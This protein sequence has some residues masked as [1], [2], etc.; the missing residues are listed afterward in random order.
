MEP[1][2][3]LQKPLRMAQEGLL[4]LA[5]LSSKNSKLNFYSYSNNL[6][7]LFFNTLYK[8]IYQQFQ[9]NLIARRMAVARINLILPYQSLLN[10]IQQSKQLEFPLNTAY[11][12]ILPLNS[13]LSNRTVYAKFEPKFEKIVQGKDELITNYQFPLKTPLF[14]TRLNVK[15]AL[16]QNTPL[17]P[18]SKADKLPITPDA[19]ATEAFTALAPI[20]TEQSYL[21]PRLLTLVTTEIAPLEEALS[22]PKSAITPSLQKNMLYERATDQTVGAEK[23]TKRIAKKHEIVDEQKL[24]SPK[25]GHV[26]KATA[27]IRQPTVND[28][29]KWQE[30]LSVKALPSAVMWASLFGPNRII[31]PTI[32]I[33]VKAST[34]PVLNFK[35]Y[36]VNQKNKEILIESRTPELLKL[37]SGLEMEDKPHKELEQIPRK[38]SLISR[39]S[40][41]SLS[42]FYFATVLPNLLM[43]QRTLFQ[44]IASAITISTSLSPQFLKPTPG[45]SQ[46]YS[47]RSVKLLTTSV[48]AEMTELPKE[49]T[50]PSSI[51]T[52]SSLSSNNR[53]S[54]LPAQFLLGTPAKTMTNIESPEMRTLSREVFPS[55]TSEIYEG[56]EA[57]RTT[58]VALSAVPIAASVAEKVITETLFQPTSNVDVPK[59]VNSED[60]MAAEEKAARLPTML[61]LAGAGNIITQ[62]LQG[63]LTKLS[64]KVA[65]HISPIVNPGFGVINAGFTSTSG[66]SAPNVLPIAATFANQLIS[67]ISEVPEEKSGSEKVAAGSIAAV[68]ELVAGLVLGAS[69]LASAARTSKATLIAGNIVAMGETN[70]RFLGAPYLRITSDS[71]KT[72]IK[73]ASR[74]SQTATAIMVASSYAAL[75]QLYAGASAEEK[76]GASALIAARSLT[77]AALTQSLPAATNVPALSPVS[78]LQSKQ[79]S[80]MPATRSY[81]EFEGEEMIEDEED[82]RDLERKIRKILSEELSRCYGSSMILGGR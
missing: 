11:D 30:A 79:L 21:I 23:L 67:A 26:E 9:F 45:S 32:S 78:K 59:L 43:E 5:R 2:D 48:S 28:L 15:K 65:V 76:A 47:G 49:Q 66:L 61:A 27:P 33:G 71:S 46:V 17:L 6:T 77:K 4:E 1:V 39:L 14:N 62:K 40:F 72:V 22:K 19:F 63:E 8:F 10:R 81:V 16:P 42:A 25:S 35:T 64:G 7:S 70:A 52:A 41:Q 73:A 37:A 38:H 44:Q 50:P 18:A 12:F 54:T 3:Y 31:S 34:T 20:I 56:S 57:L 36:G 24:A 60:G 82:L 68:S 80:V 58:N 51:I 53:P 69:Y 29:A 13:S 75:S 55:L 74:A